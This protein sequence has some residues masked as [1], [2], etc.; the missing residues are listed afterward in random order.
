MKLAN[1]L[2]ACFA[3]MVFGSVP[4][5]WAADGSST[6][7]V[8]KIIFG[9]SLHDRGPFSDRHE[10]GVDANAELQFSAP[11][12]TVWRWLGSPEP[13]I[14]IAPNFNGDTSAAYAGLS[15][16]L[17]LSN[18]WT[19][20]LTLNLTKHLFVGASLSAAVHDGPL[21]KDRIGCK[22]DSDCGFGYRVLPR[23]GFE[24]GGYF[25]TKQ[26]LSIFYDHMS[27]KGVLPGE[28]EGVD[29]IGIR[30]HLLFSLP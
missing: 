27:H 20:D 29:H 19:D 23:L 30:Y 18:R 13:M 17:S 3:Y 21:H 16:E 5:A 4:W 6:P 11:R 8:H 28:N 12:W 7:L 25:T 15:Y 22:E 10:R 14:G 9:L 1:L 24:V 2:A 26:G